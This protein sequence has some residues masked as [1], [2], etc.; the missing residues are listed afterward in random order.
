MFK[1]L[2]RNMFNL[3]PPDHSRLRSL[4][5]K[6]FTPRLIDQM[7][8][9]IE[10]LTADLLDKVQDRGQMDLIRDY[11]LPLPTTII[12]EMLGVPVEDRSK[13]HHW[14]NAII[15]AAS[16]TWRMVCA[17]PNAW[18]LMRYIRKII[19]LRRA[20]PRD[21]L[22]SELIRATEN[23]DRLSDD[24]MMAMVFV[25]LVAGHE[26]TVNLIGNGTLALLEHPDELTRL[27]SEPTLINLAV[28]EILRY[29]SPVEWATERYAREDVVIG[30]VTI[31]RGEMVHAVIASGMLPET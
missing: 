30:D 1:S 2:K 8:E 31:M 21:D 22:T 4:V 3:D 14:S 9:R 17:V 13:F 20:N 6:A 25:L 18:A 24:E 5:H 19:K 26:T 12:A 28:E 23:G 29:S 7:R 10:R 16:S 11:A 27:K 15:E